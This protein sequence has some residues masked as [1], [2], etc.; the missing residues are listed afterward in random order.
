MDGDID[1]RLTPES[2]AAF[3]VLVQEVA[4][5][6]GLATLIHHGYVS[7]WDPHAGRYAPEPSWRDDPVLSELYDY[8]TTDEGYLA[9]LREERA[10]YTK[11]RGV[12]EIANSIIGHLEH[13]GH[14]TRADRRV[15]YN[16]IIAELRDRLRA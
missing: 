5:S 16:S 2:A 4:P 13:L 3:A 15:R 9:E 14:L 8:M 12:D 6:G 1:A 11:T 7:N 10:I